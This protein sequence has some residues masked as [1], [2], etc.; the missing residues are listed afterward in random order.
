MRRFFLDIFVVG[1]IF[2]LTLPEGV[3]QN[4][5][6]QGMAGSED[7]ENTWDADTSD[8]LIAS[9]ENFFRSSNSSRYLVQKTTVRKG[10]YSIE[11]GLTVQK[12]R[13]A[14]VI[15]Q[16]ADVKQMKDMLEGEV[17]D[18]SNPSNVKVTVPCGGFRFINVALNKPLA[19]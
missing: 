7:F 18:L 12:V 8:F 11:T 19:D 17:F 1:L 10:V 3:A 16:P 2:A 5:F 4:L 15:I 14:K 6:P 9:S 13:T